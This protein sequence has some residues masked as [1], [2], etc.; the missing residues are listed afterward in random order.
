[1]KYFYEVIRGDGPV[2][3]QPCESRDH[4]GE[5]M[6]FDKPIPDIRVLLSDTFGN[7]SDELINMKFSPL[8]KGQVFVVS[9]TDTLKITGDRLFT[10]DAS[11]GEVG[12]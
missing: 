10:D 5:L 2:R 11:F 4:A 7:L 8:K 9:F 1:M 3:L 6:T 12:A